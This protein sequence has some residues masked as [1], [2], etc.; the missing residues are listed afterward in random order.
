MHACAQADGLAPGGTYTVVLHFAELYFTS[1]GQRVFSVLANGQAVLSDFDIFAAAGA[2]SIAG[3]A[4]AG[5]PAL[6]MHVLSVQRLCMAAV[7][8]EKHAGLPK[9]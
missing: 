5:A 4:G 7:Q 8:A 6:H 2:P 3:A 9:I 1:A